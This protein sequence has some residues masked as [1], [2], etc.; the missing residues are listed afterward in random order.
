MTR[1]TKRRYAHE[2]YPEPKP[3]QRS[4]LHVTLPYLFARALGLDTWGTGWGDLPRTE[5]R[6][7]VSRIE[8]Y[9]AAGQLALMADALTQGLAGAEAWA[10]VM[11]RSWDNMPEWLHERAHYYG[12]DLSLLKPYPCGTEPEYHWHNTLTGD[13]TRGGPMERVDGRESECPACTE[14]TL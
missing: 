11:D 3:D 9:V 7:S 6:Q 10:W 1:R 14:D 2:L 13:S 5:T 8:E 12:L 4:D